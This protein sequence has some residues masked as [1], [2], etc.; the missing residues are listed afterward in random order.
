MC[1]FF[2]FFIEYSG[3]QISQGRFQTLQREVEATENAPIPMNIKE[4]CSFLGLLNYYGK[5]V[6]NSSTMVQPFNPLL[7]ACKSKS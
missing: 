1:L 6:H 3:H 7:Q 2:F 5:F 4:V